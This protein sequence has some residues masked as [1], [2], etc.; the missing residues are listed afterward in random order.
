MLQKYL[1]KCYGGAGEIGHII[2]EKDGPVCNCGNRGCLTAVLTQLISL[3]NESEFHQSFNK[4][5]QRKLYNSV[6]YK[7]FCEYLAIALL[8]EYMHLY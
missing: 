8:L 3:N 1:D 5:V 2:I 4:I 6:E 7:D